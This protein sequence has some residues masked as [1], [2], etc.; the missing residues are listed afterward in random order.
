MHKN[1]RN[2]FFQSMKY[3]PCMHPEYKTLQGTVLFSLFDSY[4]FDFLIRW[5]KHLTAKSTNSS[6]N[7]SY[8][9]EQM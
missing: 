4:K 8:K 1:K 2:V 6:Y 7:E 5:K 9:A 3:R